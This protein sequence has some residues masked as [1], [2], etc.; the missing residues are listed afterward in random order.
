MRSVDTKLFSNSPVHEEVVDIGTFN[1]FEVAG[2]VL[3]S[4]STP[5]VKPELLIVGFLSRMDVDK[6]DPEQS[7]ALIRHLSSEGRSNADIEAMVLSHV[8]QKH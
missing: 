3:D 1:I 5:H 8:D 2:L 7:L 6:N 4:D